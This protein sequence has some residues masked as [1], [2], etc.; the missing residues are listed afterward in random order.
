M[1]Y[2][3]VMAYQSNI[4]LV[5][6]SEDEA[7][8]N[9][10]RSCLNDDDPGWTVEVLQAPRL[11]DRSEKHF[12]EMDAGGVAFVGGVAERLGIA[13]DLTERNA[14]MEHLLRQQERG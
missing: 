3:M 1:V 5:C 12:R 14:T 7:E 9:W 4:K 13:A 6:L 8:I 10:Y 11:D 2:L